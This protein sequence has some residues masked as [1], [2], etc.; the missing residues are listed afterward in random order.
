MDTQPE[1]TFHYWIELPE[2]EPV[3]FGDLPRLMAEAQHSDA[4]ARAA[5]E[6]NFKAELVKRISASTL[7]VRDPLT[8]GPHTFPIGESLQN[9]AVLLPSEDIRPLVGSFGIGLRLISYGTG[10]THWTIENG[11]AAIGLQESFH[12]GSVRTL[13]EQMVQAAGEGSLVVRHPHTGLAF[14][15]DA[16]RAFYELVTPDDVNTWLEK[17]GVSYRW[18]V[19]SLRMTPDAAILESGRASDEQASPRD[20]KPW[21]TLPA[22]DAHIAGLFF[23][24]LAAREIADTEGWSDTKLQALWDA[25]AGAINTGALR[26]RDRK[27]GLV[28]MPGNLDTLLLVTIDDVNDWLTEQRA[29]YRW[30]HPVAMQSNAQPGPETDQQDETP[31]QRRERLQGRHAE[32]KASGVKD[33]AKRVA[34]EE[35]ITTARLR[36]ILSGKADQPTPT[37]ADPFGRARQRQR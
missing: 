37:A 25:M 21:E 4:F 13:R 24:H 23:Y 27:T 26:T 28:R 3:K 7:L 29:P 20:F 12:A 35:R 5:A 2:A 6:I 10:P 19:T 32:V 16:V 33:Y 22:P 8:L 34:D 18:R 30:V 15:P 9:H 14:R 36:Q 17:Q 11:A 31:S 1:P